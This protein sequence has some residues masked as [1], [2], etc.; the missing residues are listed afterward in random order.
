MSNKKIN[1]IITIVSIVVVVCAGLL[2]ITVGGFFSNKVIANGI[3]VNTNDTESLLVKTYDEYNELLKKYKVSDVVLL[4]NNSFNENDYIVDFINYNKNMEISDIEL[5]VTDNGLN[6]KYIV[7]KEIK[8][9]KKKLMY[10]I[11]IQKDLL[12]E[13]N[14]NDRQFEVK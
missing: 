7:N 9:S 10:F 11:P 3:V 1:I 6:I 4:T 2:G 8:D 5:E 12:S 14:I 13:V